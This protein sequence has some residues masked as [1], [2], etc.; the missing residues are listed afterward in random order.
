MD[1]ESTASSRKAAAMAT[2]RERRERTVFVQLDSRVI[3]RRG[4][5][6]EMMNRVVGSGKV[7]AVG[8]IE[9]NWSWEVVFKESTTKEEF[10][11]A[12]VTVRDQNARLVDLQHPTRKIRIVRI[13][14]CILNDFIAAKLIERGVKVINIAYEVNKAD[15]MMSNVR[16]ATVDGKHANN[17]PDVLPW[18]FD[19][20]RACFGIH[21]RSSAEMPP[22]WRTNA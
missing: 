15:G 10:L 5:V 17:V 3:Y 20:L 19:G 18:A 14:T 13:P 21:A 8:Q 11:Q 9:K 6:I 1:R 7:E 4:D 22:M 12:H 16:I 2:Y